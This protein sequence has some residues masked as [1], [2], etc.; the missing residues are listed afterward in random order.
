MKC[1][2]CG[3]PEKARVKV[4]PKCGE[5]YATEDLLALSQLEFLLEE[6]AAWG[7]A[8]TLRS[9]Y[10]ERLESL[11]ARL[12]RR[13]P[14]EPEVAVELEAV[15]APPTLAERELVAEVA[16]AYPLSCPL[17]RKKSRRLR[18]SLR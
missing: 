6:T 16:R 15:P 4:C 8:E 13:L 9:P 18:L 3:F 12:E 1:P 11:R 17:Y 2:T 5:A 14:A 10:S 7:V